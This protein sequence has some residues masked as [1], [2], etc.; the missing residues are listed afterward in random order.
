M[1]SSRTD[2]LIE[3]P[4]GRVSVAAPRDDDGS[5]AGG[6]RRA[7]LA[8]ISVVVPVRNEESS[9]ARLLESLLAQS[10]PP[11]E[12]VITDGGSS[13]RTR[14]IIGRFQAASK[15]PV[16]LIE[17]EGSL[18][19]RGR[20]LAIERAAGEWVACIDAGIVP[21][22]DWLQELAEAA[23]R[24]PSADVI[25]GRYE[26]VTDTYFTE[27]AAIVYAPAPG[28][29]TRSIASCLLKRAAW[30]AAGGFREDLRS[31][32]DLLFFKALED[33]R[34]HAA[35]ADEAVVYWTL[36]PSTRAT[37]QRFAKYSRHGMK[38]GLAAG[39]QV[40]VT[41]LYVLMLVAALAGALF[42]LPLIGLPPLVLLLR[43][44]RR[45]GRWF[46]RASRARALAEIFNPRRLLAVAW[47]NLVID[48]AMFRGMLDWLTND[49]FGSGRIKSFD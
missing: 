24:T 21:R 47:I 30:A 6:G 11:A 31:G 41:R 14:E 37:F 5:G 23:A 10:R 44:A 12:I 43:A 33:A 46:G 9:I 18:P 4:G 16:V 29:R 17:T 7:A 20:N 39:W 34:A 27:C 42:W 19:G 49:R 2:S 8:R 26:A 40:R 25:Y 48:V 38:A 3:K 45:T 13:D 28:E 36:Q 1:A 22:A 32:E 35:F 15:L